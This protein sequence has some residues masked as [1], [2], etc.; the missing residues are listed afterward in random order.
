VTG[1]TDGGWLTS[2]TSVGL[3][4]DLSTV[5]SKAKDRDD[6]IIHGKA[7]GALFYDADG[8]GKGKQVEIA[9]LS[10]KLSLTDKG[11]FVI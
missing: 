2:W 10:K 4:K 11:F 3:K 1:L 7:K 9:A 8:S 6:Y 5:E